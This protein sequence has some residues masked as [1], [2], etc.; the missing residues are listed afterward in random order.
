[1]DRG[2]WWAT[3]H[4]VVN[5]QTRLSDLAHYSNFKA[6]ITMFKTTEVKRNDPDPKRLT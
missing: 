4:S 1:M 5:R 2:A 3:V 6:V